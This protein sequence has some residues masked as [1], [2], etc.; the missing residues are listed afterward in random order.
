MRQREPIGLGHTVEMVGGDQTA[1]AG[2]VLDDDRWVS[3][4]V[5]AEVPREKARVGVEA[6][7]GRQADDDTYGL[8]G[9]ERLGLQR[10]RAGEGQYRGHRREQEDP[11]PHAR[12]QSSRVAI[13]AP[14]TSASNFAQTTLGWISVEPANVAKPQ[15]APAMTFSRPT[16][17]ANRTMRWATSSGC[18]TSTVD[19]VMVPGISTASAGSFTVSHT[20]H[21]CSCRGFAASNEYAPARIFSITSTKCFSSR[22]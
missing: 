7:A 21:S 1:R 3:R 20:R 19:W 15:S 14:S 13:R 5:T 2:H 17:F 12:P 4:D 10:A 6:T 8:A 22:S 11:S 9:E 18:S 16:T